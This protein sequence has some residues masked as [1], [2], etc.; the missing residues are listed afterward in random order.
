MQMHIFSVAKVESN[1]MR[2][3]KKKNIKK[4]N[5]KILF[6]YFNEI[7]YQLVTL[8]LFFCCLNIKRMPLEKLKIKYIFL[9]IK[10]HNMFHHTD[11]E[12]ETNNF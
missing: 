10:L 9:F 1:K 12:A 2:K 4:F 3:E 8:S 5:D 11:V 7:P 6:C